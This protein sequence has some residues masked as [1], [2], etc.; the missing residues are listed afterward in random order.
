M[1][2]FILAFTLVLIKFVTAENVCPDGNVCMNDQ[3][4]CLIN[5]TCYGCCPYKLAVCCM[6]KIHCCPNNYQCVV[7]DLMCLPNL[8]TTNYNL[9]PVLM[10]KMEK[11]TTQEPNLG[12]LKEKNSQINSGNI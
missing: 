8:L 1:K 12:F 7:S 4:C 6:D 5:D 11:P 2:F 9:I 10:K 3:T